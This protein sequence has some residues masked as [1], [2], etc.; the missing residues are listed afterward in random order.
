MNHRDRLIK[1]DSS[2]CR[3]STGYVRLGHGCFHLAHEKLVSIEPPEATMSASDAEAFWG[4]ME[5][6]GYGAEGPKKGAPPPR[7]QERHP[8]GGKGDAAPLE[9][10]PAAPLSS[11]DAAPRP[12]ATVR[13]RD[14][15][16]ARIST[17]WAD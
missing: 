17:G 2:L 10:P 16:R 9:C 5:A 1:G 4:K 15:R 12:A 13:S 6:W 3:L 11:R 8:S 14:R 7:A